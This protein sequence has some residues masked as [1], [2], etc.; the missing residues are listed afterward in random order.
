MG[1]ELSKKSSKPLFHWEES[2]G[3]PPISFY[4]NSSAL[5]QGV[6]RRPL[7]PQ[8]THFNGG[9]WVLLNVFLQKH[10]TVRFACFAVGRHTKHCVRGL[11][12]RLFLFPAW[13]GA[14]FY[15]DTRS[16]AEMVPGSS[17]GPGHRPVC[18]RPAVF[19]AL[20]PEGAGVA[21]ALHPDGDRRR[22]R[23]LP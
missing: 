2:S 11:S 9:G 1:I 15:L 20:L 4:S 16:T 23:R 22:G 5:E 18:C 6:T 17:G 10:G 3:L 13:L 7:S 19:A 12:E 21:A 8:G 14:S